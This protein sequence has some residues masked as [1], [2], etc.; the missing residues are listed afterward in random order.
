MDM[1]VFLLLLTCCAIGPCVRKC[2]KF[3]G[4]N[5]EK[6]GPEGPFVKILCLRELLREDLCAKFYQRLILE[7]LF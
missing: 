3:C 7:A 2:L 4:E 5:V 6:N 1:A